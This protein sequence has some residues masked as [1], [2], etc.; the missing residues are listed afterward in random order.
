MFFDAP[1]KPDRLVTPRGLTISLALTTV[2]LIVLTVFPNIVLD[3]A[4]LAA[5][6][7]FALLPK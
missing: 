2:A 5:L 7:L 4:R 1:P 6:S 3:P